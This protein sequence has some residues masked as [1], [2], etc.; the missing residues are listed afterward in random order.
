MAEVD[1]YKMPYYERTWWIFL[2]HMMNWSHLLSSD[3]IL[4]GDKIVTFFRHANV[5]VWIGNI[6]VTGMQTLCLFI[7]MDF[8][9][10]PYTLLQLFFCGDW[11]FCPLKTQYYKQ[12]NQ[13]LLFQFEVFVLGKILWLTLHGGSAIWKWTTW[14]ML[15]ICIMLWWQ[16]L[17]WWMGRKVRACTCS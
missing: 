3:E 10:M 16:I 7:M 4:L 12:L 9:N 8:S 17:Q 15:F 6:C 1:F 13:F 11:M 2:I 14:W 5:W